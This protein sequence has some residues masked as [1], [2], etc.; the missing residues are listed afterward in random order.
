M[1][2][3]RGLDLDYAPDIPPHVS[4]ESLSAGDIREKIAGAFS[5][6]RNWTSPD[7]PRATKVQTVRLPVNRTDIDRLSEVRLL[8]GGQ[9][10]LMV[11]GKKLELR[12]V[13]P[14]AEGTLESCDANLVWKDEDPQFSRHIAR[15]Y[16]F[17]LVDNGETLMIALSMEATD[18]PSLVDPLIASEA[19]SEGIRTVSVSICDLD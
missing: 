1:S 13:Q 16:D 9:Y 7:G 6:Q 12:R 3:L 11:T 4:F 14:S 8:P 18:E 10:V 19:Q 2:L 15:G 17:E 5:R